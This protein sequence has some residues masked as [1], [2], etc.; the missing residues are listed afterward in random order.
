MTLTIEPVEA[1]AKLERKKEAVGFSPLKAIRRK[2][3]DCQAGG[4]K[5]VREC[6]ITTCPLHP[7]RM[8]KNPNR[9]GIGGRTKTERKV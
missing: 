1:E 5:G 3:V 2:C 8:G 6:S 4:R 7:Y 9:K